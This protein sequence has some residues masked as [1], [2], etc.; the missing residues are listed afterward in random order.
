MQQLPCMQLSCTTTIERA[1][2][3]LSFLPSEPLSLLS[4][5]GS[6]AVNKPG[7]GIVVES[8]RQS[9]LRGLCAR[10]RVSHTLHNYALPRKTA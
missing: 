3:N 5:D 6:R 8:A 4:T 7:S 2:G 10:R 1:S 9:K